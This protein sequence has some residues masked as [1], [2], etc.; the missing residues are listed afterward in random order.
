M[1]K[2]LLSLLLALSLCLSL[3]PWAGA[4]PLAPDGEYWNVI[5]GKEAQDVLKRGREGGEPILII[6]YSRMCGYS[7]TWIPKFREYAEDRGITIYALDI[8][9]DGDPVSLDFGTPVSGGYPIAIR[10]WGEGGAPVV[11][12]NIRSMEAFLE[13][14]QAP[15]PTITDGFEVD[16]GVLINYHGTEEDVVIPN[17]VKVIGPKAFY[18]N[19]TIRSVTIPNSVRKI[20][21][22]AFYF[23]TA[24]QRVSMTDSVTELGFSAFGLCTDLRE[25]RLSDNLTQLPDSAFSACKMLPHIQLPKKLQTISDFA[26]NNCSNLVSLSFPKSLTSIGRYAFSGCLA[27]HTIRFQG[28]KPSIATGE[29]RSFYN[30]YMSVVYPKNDPTWNDLSQLKAD[31]PLVNWGADPGRVAQTPYVDNWNDGT[32]SPWAV[33]TVSQAFC[34][35]LYPYSIS[36]RTN[37]DKPINRKDF[38]VLAMHMLK[39]HTGYDWLDY[40]DDSTENP[41]TDTSNKVILAAYYLGIVSGKGEGRFDPEG[42]ITREEAAVMLAHTAQLMQVAQSNPSVSFADLESISTWARDSVG[43]VSA[44]SSPVT[45]SRVMG[46]TGN[47]MFSPKM[48]YS[49]QQAYCSFLFLYQASLAN[50]SAD[51]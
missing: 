47:D 25:I 4:A 43:Y 24:L 2:R 1:K 49:L 7:K 8:Y 26:F 45:G 16:N 36:T 3:A 34:Y 19:T 41:F 50:L 20:G 31:M 14:V 10:Y 46:G 48:T 6:F 38:C 28:S 23:C 12:G 33:D 17:S 11:T 51:A 15:K 42:L 13:Q 35:G 44:I 5:S 18:N 30:Y 21:S 32:I 39:K 40:V 22:Q 9:T 37:Y 29:G 27:L